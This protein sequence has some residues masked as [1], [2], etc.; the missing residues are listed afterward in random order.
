SAAT[1]KI[2][3]AVSATEELTENA[4]DDENSTD[5]EAI[6]LSELPAVT[7]TAEGSPLPCKVTVPVALPEFAKFSRRM[8]LPSA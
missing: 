5:L 8:S 2:L 6:V 4:P 1:F 7:V 3:P